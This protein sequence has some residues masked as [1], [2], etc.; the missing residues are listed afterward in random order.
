[1]DEM[2]DCPK[3]GEECVQLTQNYWMCMVCGCVVNTEKISKSPGGRRE[4]V[5]PDGEAAT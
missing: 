4:L 2:P 1:M 3:C 5:A